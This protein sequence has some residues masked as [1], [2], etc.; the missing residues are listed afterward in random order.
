MENKLINATS[1][2]NGKFVP[3]NGNKKMNYSPED[4]SLICNYYEVKDKTITDAIENSHL[5]QLN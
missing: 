2:L 3:A 4:N 5:A 1:Y